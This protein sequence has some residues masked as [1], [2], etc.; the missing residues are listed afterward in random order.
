MWAAGRLS[1]QGRDPYLD[2]LIVDGA[3]FPRSQFPYG[4][5]VSSLFRPLGALDFDTARG[6]WFVLQVVSLVALLELGMGD[7]RRSLPT[8]GLL[9][10]ASPFF[11]FPLFALLERGQVDLLVALGAFASLRLWESGSNEAAGALLLATSVLKLPALLLFLAPL[12]ALDGAFLKGGLAA[13]MVAFGIALVTDG[14]RR[15]A[16]YFLVFLPMF[17]RSGELPTDLFPHPRPRTPL[18]PWGGRELVVSSFVAGNASLTRLL[19]R[20]LTH[21][22]CTA[23]AVTG[24]AA[25]SVVSSRA[26]LSAPASP[27]VRSVAWLAILAAML[28]LSPMTWVMGCVHAIAIPL[29][30][31]SIAA[32]GGWPALAACALG[33]GLIGSGDVLAR[34]MP[35]YIAR[36]RVVL[37]LLVLWIA[38]VASLLAQ[39]VRT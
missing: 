36:N 22:W 23:L 28:T 18:Q 32:V 11:V 24:L 29:R 17:D 31:A 7:W 16:R 9:L 2:P 6:V 3:P 38:L 26:F 12:A 14:P 27:D 34:Y 21:P 15:V 1:N 35:N 4:P 20:R 39:S 33:L 5:V 8:A 10:L 13:A 30:A 25:T 19:R 37:G